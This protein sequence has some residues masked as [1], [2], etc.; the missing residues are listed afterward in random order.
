MRRIWIWAILLVALLL[1]AACRPAEEPEQTS[2]EV[3]GVCKPEEEECADEPAEVEP[4]EV[5]AP[6]EEVEEPTATPVEEVEPEEEAED[7][8]TEAA[9]SAATEPPAVPEDDPFA[10]Q[11][12]DWVKG[13]DDAFFTLIEYG[14]FQ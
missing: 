10:I 14:D 3:A 5:E 2:A 12:T 13:S 9:E 4:A 1:V 6:A 7:A 11:D 8:P